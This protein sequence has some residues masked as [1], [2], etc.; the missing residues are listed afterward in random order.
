MFRLVKKAPLA[1]L[2]KASSVGRLHGVTVALSLAVSISGCG[3]E[4]VAI[5]EPAQPTCACKPDCPVDV[6]DLQIEIDKVSCAGKV[7]VVEILIGGVLEPGVWV[8][9]QPKRTCATVARGEV[10]HVTARA[11]TSWLWSP[12]VTCPN[13]SEPNAANGTTI[14]RVLQC[15]ARK[16]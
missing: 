6:C 8:P 12:Q 11:D 5:D 10:F 1:M 9:G 3:A 13:Q 15:L 14:A 16:K 2:Q 7:N 4:A